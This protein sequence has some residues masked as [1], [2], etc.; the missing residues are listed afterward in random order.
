MN[1]IASKEALPVHP[2]H[3]SSDFSSDGISS[4]GGGPELLVLYMLT[5]HGHQVLWTFDLA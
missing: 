5:T 1:L 4:D 3:L 2:M